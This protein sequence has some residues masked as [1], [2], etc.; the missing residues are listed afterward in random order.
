MQE[1]LVELEGEGFDLDDLRTF[2]ATSKFVKLD[3]KVYLQLDSSLY[4]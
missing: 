3:G 2:F 4:P 1:W